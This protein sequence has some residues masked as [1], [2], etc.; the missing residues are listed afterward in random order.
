MTQKLAGKIAL[1][2]GASRGIGRGIARR[3]AADGAQVAVHYGGSADDAA[4]TL[5][6]IEAAGGRG[7]LFQ[8]DVAE[9]AQ[10]RRLFADID[11]AMGSVDILINNAGIALN[12]GIKKF[13][14]EDFDKLF[15]INVRG[16]FFAM[17]E[18]AR[19]MTDWG[20][21]VNITSSSTEFAFPGMA[22]YAASRM[23]PR[24]FA[25]VAAQE[26]GKNNVTVNAVS[27]G[28][29]AP[30]M[31]ETA[32]KEMVDMVVAMTPQGRLGTPEDIAD[33][34]AFLASEDARWINGQH[35][36]ANGGG[37]A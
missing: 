34:V 36:L 18:A 6:E 32:P 8:A 31:F 9:V 12:G 25:A 26:L 15:A 16:Y 27:P 21:I 1:V 2:T 29:V 22:A 24:T 33:V 17:Q 30:G 28:P 7:R 23:A 20:R 4:Q 11:D 5:S 10:I 19:R 3:L 35:I 13:T 14:E 37:K